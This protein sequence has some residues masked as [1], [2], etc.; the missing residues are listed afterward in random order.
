MQKLDD[1]DGIKDVALVPEVDSEEVAVITA[2]AAKSSGSKRHSE[3][4]G[5]GAGDAVGVAEKLRGGGGWNAALNRMK[6][7][8]LA[9][10]VPDGEEE[11]S[12]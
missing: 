4:E 10:V 12:Q 7:A 6:P 2:S 1:S 8:W 9:S 5:K 3:S 11:K